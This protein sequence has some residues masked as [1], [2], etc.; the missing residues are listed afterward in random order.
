MI[1]DTQALAASSRILVW[2]ESALSLGEE[3]L[4]EA[5]ERVRFEV[6]AQY[7]VWVL[8]GVTIVFEEKG[9]KVENHE[10]ILVDKEG[11]VSRHDARKMYCE[12]LQLTRLRVIAMKLHRTRHD[13]GQS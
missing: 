11:E 6:T 2:P 10:I 7:G 5:I 12:C 13:V 8:M 1:H 4:I 3:E 9:V